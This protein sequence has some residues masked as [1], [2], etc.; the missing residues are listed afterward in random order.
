MTTFTNKIKIVSFTT[1]IGVV[2]CN[3]DFL[4]MAKVKVTE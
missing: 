2:M 1:K 3:L 4:A